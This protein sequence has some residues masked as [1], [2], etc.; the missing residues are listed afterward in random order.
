MPAR[1]PTPKLP[2]ALPPARP[3]PP[4]AAS[5]L[6]LDHSEPRPWGCGDGIPADTPANGARIGGRLQRPLGGRAR[7]E[8]I[9]FQRDAAAVAD[10]ADPPDAP[11][12]GG[13][14]LLFILHNYRIVASLGLDKLS[15]IA[16][17]VVVDKGAG[18]NLVRRRALAPDWLRQVVA[19]KEE[20]QV[21]LRDANNT[22]LRTSGTV[23]LW[24]QTSARIVPVAFLVV[25][26]Q[27][28][29]VII[30]ATPESSTRGAATA[31]PPT[32]VEPPPASAMRPE[33]GATCQLVSVKRVAYLSRPRTMGVPVGP[34]PNSPAGLPPTTPPP[35]TSLPALPSPSLSTPLGRG[36]LTPARAAYSRTAVQPTAPVAR[37]P[38]AMALA[39][40]GA[41]E[42]R[43]PAAVPRSTVDG[44]DAMASSG[45]AGLAAGG[46]ACRLVAR[47]PPPTLVSTS[48]GAS[49]RRATLSPRGGG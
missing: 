15:F 23:T 42:A 13:E 11:S 1:P 34:A 16:L 3:A 44:A 5:V 39:A 40:P 19:P 18:P 47:A 48:T 10:P 27:L 35:K 7:R 21:R 38:I 26:D 4:V 2:V 36:A 12:G 17:G 37:S 14:V 30:G 8:R 29:P 28:V 20:E 25:D 45:D 32:A 24:L 43:A 33:G 41:P 31:M 46:G 49:R 22:R 9:H 6:D